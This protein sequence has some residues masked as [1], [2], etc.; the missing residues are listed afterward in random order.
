MY[1]AKAEVLQVL[2]SVEEQEQEDGLL[3]LKAIVPGTREIPYE[4]RCQFDANGGQGSGSV[5]TL[6]C[7]C[8]AA[9][10]QPIC[11][12]GI[13]VLLWHA[14]VRGSLPA[15]PQPLEPLPQV[16]PA[17]LAPAAMRRLPPSLVMSQAATAPRATEQ[18]QVKFKAQPSKEPAAAKPQKLQQEVP[19]Q[20]SGCSQPFW[21][22]TASCFPTLTV[23]CVVV[24]RLQLPIIA[25]TWAN[26]VVQGEQETHAGCKR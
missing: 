3:L 15:P 11:K 24:L 17:A 16:A 10:K 21:M 7:N 19:R 5:V 20:R 25:E 13:A 26:D 9:Q 4:V 14:G 18:K 8:L 1:R 6:E 2:N 12:H 23:C 22:T